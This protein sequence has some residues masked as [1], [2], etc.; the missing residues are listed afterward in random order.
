MEF[1]QVKHILLCHAIYKIERVLQILS[2][3]AAQVENYEYSLRIIFTTIH[4]FW[5][6]TVQRGGR[7]AAGHAW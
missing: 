4:H 2:K 5:D 3:P 1:K 7:G 6:F